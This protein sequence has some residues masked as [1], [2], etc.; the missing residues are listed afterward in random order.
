MA[1]LR[2]LLAD[3]DTSFRT[4]AQRAL[5]RQ[6]YLVI[7]A[8][9]GIDAIN[10][11]AEDEVDVVVADVGLPQRDGLEVLHAAK[12]KS[13]RT[14]VILL[15]Q[16]GSLASAATGV[17][18][19][20][21]DYLVKPLDDLGRLME[22]VDRAAGNETAAP[23]GSPVESTS[24]QRASED[25]ASARFVEAVA[26]GLE[27][28]RLLALYAKEL[29]NL[30]RASQAVVLLAHSDGLL[31]VEGASG[32]ADRAE[33]GRTFVQTGGEEFA[34]SVAAARDLVEQAIHSVEGEEENSGSLSYLGLPLL[35]AREV[36]G[37][38]VVFMN[39]PRSNLREGDVAA[40]RYLSQQASIAVE[41]ARVRGLAERR[42][43]TDAVTGLLNREHFFD[44]ADREFRRSWRFG[45]R[46]AALQLDVDEFSNL[47]KIQGPD[48]ADEI[49]RQ[50]ARSVHQH[51][52]NIDVVGRLDVDKL[53]ILLMNST[54]ENA[55]GVAERLRRSV[56]EIELATSDGTWQVTA[57]LG[58]AVYPREQCASI[59]D[60]FGMAAQ[61]ARAA[62]RGGHNRVVGV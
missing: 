45:E 28:S 20:A 55:M 11:L 7:P 43:P 23:P 58:V 17:R 49:V 27:M 52:R 53:G 46:I 54:R 48:E 22:L 9:N 29:A 50:I 12:A 16:P 35:Y 3:G 14:P 59:H 51:V 40:M 19:G 30:A 42:N 21:S 56:A 61:A 24:G 5:T 47:H 39:G 18:E 41:L 60:L 44:Q 8:A 32:F 33:A 37:V 1:N 25:A 38:A 34:Y 15:A 10:L 31:H 57:S 4:T 26:S 36:L 2:V 62:K 13:P 6:G